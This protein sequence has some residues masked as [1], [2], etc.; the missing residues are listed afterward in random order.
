MT[1]TKPSPAWAQKLAEDIEMALIGGPLS[2]DWVEIIQPVLASRLGP[3]I[4]AISSPLWLVWSNEHEA[5]WKPKRCG[6]T[7]TIAEAGRYTL[8]A[9]LSCCDTRSV[10]PDGVPNEITQP[11]PELVESLRAALEQMEKL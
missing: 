2:G 9:A 5:W 3:V 4:E 1:Q 8:A 11:S 6:Y 10:R 7:L